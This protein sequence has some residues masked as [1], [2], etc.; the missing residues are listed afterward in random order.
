[1]QCNRFVVLLL[2]LAAGFSLAQLTGSVPSAKVAS[3]P[4][5]DATLPSHPSLSTGAEQVLAFADPEDAADDPEGS[6]WVRKTARV[7]GSASAQMRKM[8]I[9]QQAALIAI[10]ATE[11]F[12]R[13]RKAPYKMVD[14]SLAVVNGNFLFEYTFD[15]FEHVRPR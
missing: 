3:S 11:R 5:T 9:V 14:A 1:M 6:E 15:E 13:E 4:V 7:S 8:H 10:Q 12:C 2:G